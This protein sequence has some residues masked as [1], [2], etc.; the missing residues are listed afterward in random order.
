MTGTAKQRVLPSHSILA[1]LRYNRSDNSKQCAALTVCFKASCARWQGRLLKRITDNAIAHRLTSERTCGTIST[2][3]LTFSSVCLMLGLRA[4]LLVYLSSAR[5]RCVIARIFWLFG[6]GRFGN[7]HRS[8]RLLRVA[9]CLPALCGTTFGCC[10]VAAGLLLQLRQ[11]HGVRLP[12]LFSSRRLRSFDQAG[13]LLRSG[14][15]PLP[16]FSM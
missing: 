6:L 5:R 10:V 4:S 14:K 15:Q 9:F 8:H 1:S 3:V 7:A 16:T 11:S 12:P 2:G 13:F